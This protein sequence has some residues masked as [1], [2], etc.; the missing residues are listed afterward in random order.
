[1]IGQNRTANC[2]GRSENHCAFAT[3]ATIPVILDLEKLAECGDAI[4]TNCSPDTTQI[5]GRTVLAQ[6][7]QVLLPVATSILPCYKVRV[8]MHGDFLN[9]LL[10]DAEESDCG[11]T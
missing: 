10:S 5:A 1:M 3:T 11:L 6:Y 8:Q 4:L 2:T 7:V 9:A